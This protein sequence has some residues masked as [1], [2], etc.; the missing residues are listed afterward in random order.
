MRLLLL[1]LFLLSPFARAVET[2]PNIILI[3]TDDMG[4]G[5]V[6]LEKTPPRDNSPAISTPTLSRLAEEG[7]LLTQHYSGAP[8]C[9]P[10]RACLFSGVHQ[11]H[12]QVIRNNNFDAPLEDSHTLATVLKTAGYATALI[13]KWGIGGGRQNGGTPDAAAWPTRRGFDFFFGYHNH[14]A[15]HRHYPREEASVDPDNGCNAVWEGENLITEKLDNCYST[16]LFTARAKHWIKE[17]CTAHPD[18]P[19]FLALTLT[20]PHARLALPAAPYPKDGG[21]RGGLQWTGRP[22]CM[23]NTATGKWDSYIDSQYL[24]TP[25]WETQA[26]ICRRGRETV[27]QLLNTARRHAT[28]VTRIDRVVEDLLLLCRDLRIEKHTFLV[29]LSDNGPHN[30]P[31]SLASLPRHPAPPQHPDFFRSYGSLDGIKR[32]VWE[33][34]LRV[35]C[36]VYAPGQIREGSIS[37]HPSQFHDWM[38]TFAELAQVPV[39]MRCDGVSLLP[40]LQ[41]ETSRQKPGIVYTEYAYSGSM[42]T[43]PDYAP[44]KKNRRRGEQQVLLF[45]APNSRILKALRT[46]IQTGNEDF[47]L[48]DVRRD[49]H[50]SRNLAPLYPELQPVLKTAVLHN[51][52]AWDYVRDSHAATRLTPCTGRRPYDDIPIPANSIS[53]V[54]PGWQM[55]QVKGECPWVP[56]MDTLPGASEA[57]VSIIP[58][59]SEVELPAGS[60]TEFRGYLR[61][62]PCEEPWHFF[63][64]LD[65]V[66]G[67]RAFMR[68]HRFHLIDAD[69]R[70]TPGTT[71][72]ESSAAQAPEALVGKNGQRG[73]R[74]CSGLHEVCLVVV[75]GSSASGRLKLE[76]SHGADRNT[77]PR[78]RLLPKH[79]AHHP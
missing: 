63:L 60:I 54:R 9:A 55:R 37:H 32:D 4:W 12:A 18:Q 13:G 17:H 47:E 24:D 20:A 53:D 21:L 71:A 2:R 50:E 14:I 25:H 42:T 75:Q 61:V 38:A 56:D 30:E 51:R 5:D 49:S 3:L 7:V 48:Y 41:G 43:Y 19:F 6:N 67:S 58:D 22:G 64:T 39:P 69:S 33:G 23:I 46:D 29:F 65:A 10:A 74:L 16:D 52:R 78:S 57:P 79:C 76:W 62:P 26:R 40:L 35:P 1:C 59:P 27:E 66:P 15:G 72:D 34:G 36:I 28:I 31:G 44:N 11:G 70:Y 73:I 77:A 8:V 68:M 45:R